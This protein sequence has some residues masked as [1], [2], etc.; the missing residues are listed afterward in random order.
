MGAWLGWGK[1]YGTIVED[2]WTQQGQVFETRALTLIHLAESLFA[3]H[4][5]IFSGSFWDEQQSYLQ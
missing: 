2:W 5:N 3:A 1:D 4:L